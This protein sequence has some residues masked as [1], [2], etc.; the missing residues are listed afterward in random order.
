MWS[1]VLVVIGGVVS[2]MVRTRLGTGPT[3]TGA[4]DAVVLSL[5]AA[6][7]LILPIVALRWRVGPWICGAALLGWAP[8]LTS[9]GDTSCTDCGFV[10]LIPL[11]LTGIELV[12]FLVALL[13][14]G[15]RRRSSREEGPRPD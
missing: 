12:L 11:N 5:L 15:L 8:L 3:E 4:A 13:A 9:A 2:V 7:S 1:T 6:P 14:P 10:L